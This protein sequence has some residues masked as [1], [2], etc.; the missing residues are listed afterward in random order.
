M[1]AQQNT[2]FNALNALLEEAKRKGYLLHEDLLNL[3]PSDYGD[4]NQMENIIEW[5]GTAGI[6][7]F[8]PLQNWRLI[9]TRNP[10]GISFLAFSFV[11]IGTAG[12]LALGIHL[13]ILGLVIG[14]ASNFF[15]ASL[16]LL[17]VWFRSSALTR[18]ERIAGLSVFIIGIGFLSILHMI[19]S[20]ETAASIVGWVGMFGVIA[21]YPAQNFKL[22]KR[23]DPT[24]L[25]L[26]AFVSLAAGLAFYTL[27]GFVVKDTT[28]ILGNGVSFLGC[29]PIIWMILRKKKRA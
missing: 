5:L 13:D 2:R 4:P 27:L 24:G 1:S 18:R 3:L 22:F 11:A 14:N 26:V 9:L 20:R 19:A 16:I 7:A 10:V 12:Y 23:K 29:L 17:L 25:S 15:F 8:Y 28:I 21:F 6:V